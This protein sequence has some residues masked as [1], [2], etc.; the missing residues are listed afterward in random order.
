MG[1]VIA[2]GST[3]GCHNKTENSNE[4][5]CNIIPQG[6]LEGDEYCDGVKKGTKE[7]WNFSKHSLYLDMHATDT[8][9]RERMLIWELKNITKN[10]VIDHGVWIYGSDDPETE[11]KEFKLGDYKKIISTTNQIG[12]TIRIKMWSQDGE[13]MSSLFV[14]L[15]NAT[16]FT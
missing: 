6:M 7:I 14:F 11:E 9:D 10:E 4:V 5:Y 3:G 1:I 13:P 15:C 12:D 16:Y 8:T 2:N